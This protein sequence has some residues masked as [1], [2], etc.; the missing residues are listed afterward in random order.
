[1]KNLSHG[2]ISLFI[3]LFYG[4]YIKVNLFGMTIGFYP[5]GMKFDK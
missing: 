5:Y 3:E 1:M 2:I 4:K